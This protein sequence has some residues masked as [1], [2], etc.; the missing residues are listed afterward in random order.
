MTQQVE[1]LTAEDLD[2]Y[3]ELFSGIVWYR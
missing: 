2:R 1:R 3:T